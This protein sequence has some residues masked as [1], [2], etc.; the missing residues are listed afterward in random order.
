[1]SVSACVSVPCFMYRVCF[2][3]PLFPYMWLIG[4]YISTYSFSFGELVVVEVTW[5]LCVSAAVGA[6]GLCWRMLC[7]WST[8]AVLVTFLQSLF[9]VFT[10]LHGRCTCIC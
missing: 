2:V 8:C 10:L 9:L 1:M 6:V 7:Q 4:W 5:L 3:P